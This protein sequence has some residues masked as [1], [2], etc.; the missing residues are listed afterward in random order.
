[1]CCARVAYASNVQI[2]SVAINQFDEDD[3]VQSDVD[4]AFALRIC[5]GD[6]E[7]DCTL[8][9]LGFQVTRRQDGLLALGGPFTGAALEQKPARNC[10][11]PPGK[12]GLLWQPMGPPVIR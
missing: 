1:M 8:E 11:G 2:T 10:I 7:A 9:L 3:D 12:A 4:K 5:L 6:L